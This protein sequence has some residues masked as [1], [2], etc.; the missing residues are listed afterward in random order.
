MKAAL[1]GAALLAAPIAATAEELSFFASVDI[2]TDNL[3]AGTTQTSNGPAIQPYL[4]IGYGGAYLGIFATNVDFGT[5]DSAEV[6]VSLGYRHDFAGGQYLDVGYARYLFNG[7]TG[8]C[9]GE[10]YVIAGSPITE[11]AWGELYLAY[12]PEAETFD[13]KVTLGTS[14]TDEIGVKASFGKSDVFANTYWDVTAS[15]QVNDRVS[16]RV[17]YS[18]ASTGD[19]GLF[20]GISIVLN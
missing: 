11:K 8:N 20:A 4:S 19:E 13:R 18:G 14:L 6:D 2:V 10:A 3:V 9:C 17:G 12:D 7:V 1:F 15:Y 5:N 16:G